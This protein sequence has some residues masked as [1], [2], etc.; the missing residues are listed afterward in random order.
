VPAALSHGGRCSFGS[1]LTFCDNSS[2]HILLCS[3]YVDGFP[4]EK[5]DFSFFILISV[6]VSTTLCISANKQ[7]HKSDI[8]TVATSTA[9]KSDEYHL[10]TPAQS[11]N[12]NQELPWEIRPPLP[13]QANRPCRHRPL[14]NPALLKSVPRQLYPTPANFAFVPPRPCSEA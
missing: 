10:K 13:R 11:K 1:C 9:F 12:P 2:L 6:V 7:T 5:I 8:H 3:L 4:F 14:T